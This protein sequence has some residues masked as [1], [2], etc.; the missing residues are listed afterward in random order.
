MK[1]NIIKLINGIF[2][3]LW[4]IVASSCLELTEEPDGRT[5]ATHYYNSIAQCESGVVASWN[6]WYE[7]WRGYR[8]FGGADGAVGVGAGY[9]PTQG[10]SQWELHYKSIVNCLTPVIKAVK[11]GSLD[12]QGIPQA[13]IN[14]VL[15]QAYF[16]RAFNYFVLVQLWGPVPYIDE[17]TPDVLGTPLTPE[18]RMPISQVY[19][20]IVDDLKFASEHMFDYNGARPTRANKWTAKALLAKVYLTMA[21][22]PLNKTD[23]YAL[24]R[25]MADDVIV[26]SRYKLLPISEIFRNTNKNNDEILFAWQNTA[27]YVDGAG[28]GSGPEDWGSW[29]GGAVRATYANNYP[30][31]PRKYWYIRATWPVRLVGADG[32]TP[33]DPA[34]YVWRRWQDANDNHPFNGKILWPQINVEQQTKENAN[35]SGNYPVLRITEQYLIYAEAANMA[36]GAPSQKAVDRINAIINRANTQFV[37]EIPETSTVVGTEQLATTSMTQAE[38]AQKIWDERYWELLGEF[39]TYFD[40][41]RHRKL[42]EVNTPD[43]LDNFSEETNYLYPIPKFDALFIGQNPGYPIE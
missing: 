29:G 4:L 7:Q 22:N 38:F 31:Q 12:G 5:F 34:T 32:S 3:L 41:L 27:E 25:D 43:G 33:L 1:K 18:S 21:T 19:D 14:D 35:A 8:G 2:C 40:V 23:C 15:G 13:D 24:A 28:K 36:E 20:R 37:S 42:R 30:E 11:S 9:L 16:A 26:N 39:S 6:Q 10:N 17:N